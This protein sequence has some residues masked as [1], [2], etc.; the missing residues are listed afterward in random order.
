VPEFVPEAVAGADARGSMGERSEAVIE[1]FF[2][3]EIDFG[4]TR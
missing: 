4:V 3:T 1:H 2:G